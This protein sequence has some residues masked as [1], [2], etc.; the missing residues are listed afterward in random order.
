MKKSWSFFWIITAFSVSALVV[1]A[2]FAA[3]IGGM[4]CA[5]CVILGAAGWTVFYLH[6][7]TIEY[8]VEND[9][10]TI[11]GG[12]FIRTERH[13]SISDILWRTTVK[14]GS[15]MLFSVVH[16]TAGRAVIFVLSDIGS[17]EPH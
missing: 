12:F 17:T 7:R 10:L 6:F 3:Q 1:G 11:C 14:I 13:I 5:V 9:R 8:I 4:L 16:T 15:V 2:A